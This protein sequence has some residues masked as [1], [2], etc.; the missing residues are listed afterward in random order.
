MD[1]PSKAPTRAS[2]VLKLLTV[3]AKQFGMA[4]LMIVVGIAALTVPTKLAYE[5]IRFLW[6]L[7]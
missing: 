6:N 7:V 4:Y 5:L 2:A 1:N 3:S